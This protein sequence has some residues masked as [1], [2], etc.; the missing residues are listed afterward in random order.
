MHELIERFRYRLEL[1]RHERREDLFGPPVTHPPDD[2]SDY[3]RKYGSVITESTP[4]FLIRS[5]AVYFGIIII[6]AQLAR[7]VDIFI[8]PARFSVSVALVVLICL[9]TLMMAISTIDVCKA[10]K[11]HRDRSTPII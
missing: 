5:V 10:R 8:P 11:S 3:I 7:L 6:L 9:W 4:R 1:W 2:P